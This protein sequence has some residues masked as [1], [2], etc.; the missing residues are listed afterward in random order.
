MA[1]KRDSGKGAKGTR[2]R[3][4]PAARREPA[5]PS[6]KPR[7]TGGR[8][9]DKEKRR[10]GEPPPPLVPVS[11]CPRVSAPALP[12]IE[13]RA[14]P[15]IGPV[16]AGGMTP[17]QRAFVAYY[18]GAACFNA[19]R[20]AEL[21]G[22]RSEHNPSLRVTASRLLT[23]ANIQQAIAAGFG[24]AGMSPEHV[25]NLVASLAAGSMASFLDLD[26]R[27]QPSIDWAKAAAAGAL[28]QVREFSED[29]HE[30]PDGEGKVIKRRLK[31]FDRLKAADLLM[32]HLGM[33]SDK[34]DVRH[35]GPDGGPVEVKAAEP[36]DHDEFVREFE[37]FIQ[38]G[39]GKL[40]GRAAAANG[41]GKPMDPA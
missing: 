27:G 33:F 39:A 6:R 13:A 35:T 21:A 9:G 18:L 11:P 24:A 12:E 15:E 10:Q 41:P 31:L 34:L 25:R 3:P 28:G 5:P 8:K 40:G 37:R 14:E 38:S 23:N 22:Y 20:A 17:R 1:R 4:T 26:E 19:T 16:D 7:K 32:R 2:R 30:L 29:V 36:F